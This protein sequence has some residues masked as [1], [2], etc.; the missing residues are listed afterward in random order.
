M[1][2]TGSTAIFSSMMSKFFTSRAI[3]VILVF[4]LGYLVAWITLPSGPSHSANE[5]PSQ[6]ESRM[7]RG[8][9]PSRS[10]RPA[11][12]SQSETARLKL[13]EHWENADMELI[14]EKLDSIKT[15]ES[16]TFDTGLSLE[17]CEYLAISR[18]EQTAIDTGI[19][20][21]V[22]E[23]QRLQISSV[24]ATQVDDRTSK[25]VI[26]K[27][28]DQGGAIK[29]ALRKTIRETLG[30]NRYFLFSKISSDSL[31]YTF[32]D[33]GETDVHITMKRSGPPGPRHY[34]TM[35]FTERMTHRFETEGVPPAFEY[36]LKVE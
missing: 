20:S 29:E 6:K 35:V 7:G 13:V 16:N 26:K 3:L 22:E 33:Y 15:F 8:S 18:S 30:D 36:L 28:P 34:E 12:A 31:G 10:N 24:E 4:G 11:G 21:A 9:L 17:L 14:I 5:S 1:K 2:P 23:L 25:F 27:F 32:L 19:R